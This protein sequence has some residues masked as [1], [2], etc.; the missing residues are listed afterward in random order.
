MDKF[1]KQNKNIL[2]IENDIISSIKDHK[3]YEIL[4]LKNN[5]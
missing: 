1:I 2:K 5:K 3:N 4:K